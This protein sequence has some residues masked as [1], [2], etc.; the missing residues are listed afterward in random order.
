M[1]LHNITH[2]EVSARNKASESF[3]YINETYAELSRE[4][5]N[6]SIFEVREAPF[7]TESVYERGIFE[8]DAVH[9]SA[10]TNKWVAEQILKDYKMRKAL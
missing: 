8:P 9:Y 3:D 5:E 6:I 2:E 1:V 7:Y 10:K 4:N